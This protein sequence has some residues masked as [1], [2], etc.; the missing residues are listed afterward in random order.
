[1]AQAASSTIPAKIITPA[2]KPRTGPPIK[3]PTRPGRAT[4]NAEPSCSLG[5]C[6]ARRG[7]LRLVRRH[8]GANIFLGQHFEVGANFLVEVYVLAMR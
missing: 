6:R 7:A 1:L 5:Y 3:S 8:A 2:I 4:L